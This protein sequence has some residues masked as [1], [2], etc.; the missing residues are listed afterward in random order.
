MKKPTTDEVRTLS[1]SFRDLSIE[2]G[3]Y[4]DENWSSIPRQTGRRI[5]QLQDTLLNQAQALN[6]MALELRLD[7]AEASLDAFSKVTGDARKA[8]KR[9]TNARSAVNILTG[10]IRLTGAVMSRDPGAIASSLASM[11]KEVSDLK[12][13]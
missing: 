4:L 12:T 3:K 10:A 9:L 6:V 2:V 5:E 13:A 1:R 8:V 11:A 7:D